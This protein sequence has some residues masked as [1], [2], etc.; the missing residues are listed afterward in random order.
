MS[1]LGVIEG[2]EG[3]EVREEVGVLSGAER[4]QHRHAGKGLLRVGVG[5][6][7]GPVEPPSPEKK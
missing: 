2:E 1:Y 3:L 6:L 4:L 7:P 5:G